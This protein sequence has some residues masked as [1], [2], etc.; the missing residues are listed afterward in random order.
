[1]YWQLVRGDDLDTTVGQKDE[2]NTN[3]YKNGRLETRSRRLEPGSRRPE[4]R[5]W[6]PEAGSERPELEAGLVAKEE[7]TN[8]K[9]YHYL[10]SMNGY[11]IHKFYPAR[12]PE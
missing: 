8:S 1:V 4:A 11:V 12:Y 6:K 9:I 10:Y 7:K 5:G 2:Q 3:I